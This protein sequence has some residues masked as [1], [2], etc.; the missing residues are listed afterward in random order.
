MHDAFYRL[1]SLIGDT[2]QILEHMKVDAKHQHLLNQ[3][4]IIL[5]EQQKKVHDLYIQTSDEIFQEAI[6][7]STQ[8]T[9]VDDLVQQLEA[10]L[11]EDYNKS[12]NHSIHEYE[13]MSIEAQMSNEVAY[14]DKIDY[15]S[16]VKVRKNLHRMNELLLMI[17]S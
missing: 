13:M 15:L 5:E 3:I 8:I 11:Y 9:H 4:T 14:H 6:T 7:I 16:A 17:R 1:E 10:E 2:L 12:T